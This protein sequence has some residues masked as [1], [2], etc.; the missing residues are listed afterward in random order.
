ML[1]GGGT[2]VLFSEIGEKEKM[3]IEFNSTID[4]IYS[5]EIN[6]HGS[7]SSSYDDHDLAAE[8]VFDNKIATKDLITHTFPLEKL[9][10]AVDLADKRV[11]SA[12]EGESSSEDLRESFKVVIK[13]N[14]E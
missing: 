4:A 13:P 12:W 2:I 11:G 14:G 6:A 8:Y 9:Y 10:E 1:R 5:R 3:T 7:Y